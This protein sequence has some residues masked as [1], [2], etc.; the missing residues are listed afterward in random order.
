M[1]NLAEQLFGLGK[2]FEAEAIFRD[3]A[4]Q[5]ERLLSAR[6]P[7]TL[8]STIDVANCLHYQGKSRHATEIGRH[9]LPLLREVLGDNHPSTLTAMSNLAWYEC[10]T[11]NFHDFVSKMTTVYHLRQANLGDDH[12]D[13]V[14][15]SLF[16]AWGQCQRRKFQEAHKIFDS[17]HGQLIKI[18][19][20]R[21]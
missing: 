5:R 3:Q 2:Y 18:R 11:L 14:R 17:T 20:L 19:G 7:R 12:P 1:D 21:K 10:N 15:S 9:I 6:H 4:S 13:T 8:T 16:L